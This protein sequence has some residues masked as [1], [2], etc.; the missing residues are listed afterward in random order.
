M[1]ALDWQLFEG[2]NALGSQLVAL[3]KAGVSVVDAAALLRAKS[4]EPRAV[5]GY[6]P[7]AGVRHV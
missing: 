4:Y 3:R 5:A 6:E 1:R 2:M 7:G